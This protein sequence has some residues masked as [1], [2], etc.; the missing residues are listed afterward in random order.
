MLH[1]LRIALSLLR[2]SLEVK[3]LEELFCGYHQ[4]P[5]Q[6]FLTMLDM[7]DKNLNCPTTSSLGRIFDAASA[8]LRLV[9]TVSYEGEG[10]ILLEGLALQGYRGEPLDASGSRFDDGISVDQDTSGF[11]GLDCSH[12]LRSLA[13]IRAGD[14][15]IEE[16]VLSL[17]ALD[18]HKAIAAA[19]LEGARRMMEQ[20]GIPRIALSGGVFQNVLLTELLVPALQ[21]EGFDVYTHRDVPAGDGGIAVGQVYFLPGT[22]ETIAPEETMCLAVPM[23]IVKIDSAGKALVKQDDLET[24]VDLTLIEDPKV[25]DYVIIHAGY[26]IDLLD[27][28]EALERLKLFRAMEES[29]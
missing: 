10:P 5:E 7:I 19:A 9:D 15:Q 16:S 1:P 22:E 24:E 17:L 13:L 14:P 21:K 11:F 4:L 25:G 27:L 23:K 8:L 3:E 6:D 28:E 2:E 12:A 26:A 20:T 29:G 18:F